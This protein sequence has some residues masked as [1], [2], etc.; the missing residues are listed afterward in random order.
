MKHRDI[1]RQLRPHSTFETVKKEER[2]SSELLDY[3]YSL[4]SI[5]L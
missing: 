4:P 2:C 3:R 5:V 1:V